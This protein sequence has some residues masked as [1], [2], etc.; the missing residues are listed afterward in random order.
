[1]YV[2]YDCIPLQ[3]CTD[4]NAD[5]FNGFNLDHLNT[6]L[7]RGTLH[8][9]MSIWYVKFHLRRADLWGKEKI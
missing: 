7:F 6:D 8:Q 2:L 4:F 9:I 3:T 5:I 1:M